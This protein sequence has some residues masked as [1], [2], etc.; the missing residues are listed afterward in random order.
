MLDS[1]LVRALSRAV[2]LAVL[3][4]FMACKPGSKL[5]K[6]SK[7]EAAE[8]KYR[9]AEVLTGD[10][11]VTVAATG[12]VKAIRD[13]DVLSKASGEITELPH[14]TGDFVKKGELLIRVDPIDEQ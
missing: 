4:L 6:S 14:E 7:S 5:F 1:S 8:Q 12:K 10:F 9:T 2:L 3:S 13:V 11:R